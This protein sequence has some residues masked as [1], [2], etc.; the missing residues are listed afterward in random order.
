MLKDLLK[1]ELR[2][3]RLASATLRANEIP[4]YGEALELRARTS[5]GGSAD[6]NRTTSNLGEHLPFWPASHDVLTAARAASG[7]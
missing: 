5:G 6:H 2:K 3:L 1:K 7:L 4:T